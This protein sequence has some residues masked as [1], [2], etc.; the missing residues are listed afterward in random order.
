MFG[1]GKRSDNVVIVSREE[2]ENLN[3]DV[4]GLKRLADLEGRDRSEQNTR[5]AQAIDTLDARTKELQTLIAT[6]QDVLTRNA[7]EFSN[8]ID[9]VAAAVGELKAARADDVALAFERIDELERA[10]KRSTDQLG[11]QV[12]RIDALVDSD[13]VR[14]DGAQI[15]A[16]KAELAATRGELIGRAEVHAQA[17]EQLARDLIT[18]KAPS[19]TNAI[20]AASPPDLDE[21]RAYYAEKR[22][23]REAFVA[24][25]GG[26]L[27]DEAALIDPAA[28][29][30]AQEALERAAEEPL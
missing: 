22:A 26:A 25:N 12:V 19:L 13:A 17:I 9:R 8:R 10:S 29:E 15:A 2:W 11:E 16:I 14:G 1:F 20:A 23:E 24:Q 3:A 7:V 27:E 5:F 21:M 18:S 28:H 4:R 30:M 6:T